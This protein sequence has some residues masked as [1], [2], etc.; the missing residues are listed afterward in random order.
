M[1]EK[2]G[3]DVGGVITES[4]NEMFSEQFLQ[5]K[6][7]EGAF[8]ALTKLRSRFDDH[9]YVVSKCGVRMQQKTVE[10]MRHHGFR[11]LLVF[12]KVRWSSVWNATIRVEL[13]NDSDSHTS[14]TIG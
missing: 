6:Q 9:I 3:V 4:G 12:H 10:W 7:M 1:T 14:S 2:L 8:E 11:E 5:A 13:H